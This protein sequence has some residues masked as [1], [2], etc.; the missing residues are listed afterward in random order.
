MTINNKQKNNIFDFYF[1]FNIRRTFTFLVHEFSVILIMSNLF[2]NKDIMEVI[3]RRFPAGIRNNSNRWKYIYDLKNIY[4]L[5][6]FHIFLFILNGI[7]IKKLIQKRW[8]KGNVTSTVYRG[9]VSF[10]FLFI[11]KCFYDKNCIIYRYCVW[12]HVRFVW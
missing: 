10:K 9:N 11:L 8:E 5:G 1:C 12:L 2:M 3:K 6:I 7:R 4:W